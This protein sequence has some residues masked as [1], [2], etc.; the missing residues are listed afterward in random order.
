MSDRLRRE[1]IYWRAFAL[2]V[3]LK[4]RDITDFQMELARSAA[5]IFVDEDELEA[6]LDEF[7][8]ELVQ[9]LSLITTPGVNRRKR[10]QKRNGP[11][12]N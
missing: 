4:K 10:P 1:L 11:R 7:D 6:V 12:L 5:G 2:L 8:P 3:L 9:I